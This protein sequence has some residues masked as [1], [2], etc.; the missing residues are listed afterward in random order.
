MYC[1][2]MHREKVLGNRR[3]YIECI[4]EYIFILANSRFHTS[5]EVTRENE[6]F[7]EPLSS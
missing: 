3:V 2:P 6:K 7:P 5:K 1:W 4:H